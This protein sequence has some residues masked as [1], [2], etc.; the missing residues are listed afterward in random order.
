MKHFSRIAVFMGCLIAPIMAHA[1][2]RSIES[3]INAGQLSSTS[4]KTIQGMLFNVTISDDNPFAMKTPPE[5]SLVY[6]GMTFTSSTYNAMTNDSYFIKLSGAIHNHL[7]F[8]GGPDDWNISG[9]GY[10]LPA[11]GPMTGLDSG[12][13]RQLSSEWDV[14][15]NGGTQRTMLWTERDGS[16]HFGVDSYFGTGAEPKQGTQLHQVGAGAKQHASI[17][18]DLKNL[19][20]SIGLCGGD[21]SCALVADGTGVYTS[22][23]HTNTMQY[24]PTKT[25]A[26]PEG[27]ADGSSMW[28]SDCVKN[29]ITGVLVY[30]H[31]KERVWT[32][33]DNQVIKK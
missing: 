13:L 6:Q 8:D 22:L 21:G 12:N 14:V 32:D 18:W 26:L 16:T 31:A 20:N 17:V 33:A 29:N 3:S 5:N 9:N 23:I 10:W 11:S 25:T 19:P 28:C 15:R 30:Y 4:P 7:L 24:D 2:T 1:Q 27:V